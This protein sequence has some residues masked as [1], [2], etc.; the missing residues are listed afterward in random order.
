MQRG[1]VDTSTALGTRELD[2]LQQAGFTILNAPIPNIV[3]VDFALEKP[4][5]DKKEVRQ[6]I[7]YAMPYSNLL[8][9]VFSGRGEVATSYVNPQ[10]PGFLPAFKPYTEGDTAKAKDLLAKAGVGNGF[11]VDLYYDNGVPYNENLALVV[12]DALRQLNI[13]VTLKAEP[14]TQFAD[15]R[16]ARVKGQQVMQGMLLQSAVIWLDDPDPNTDVWV[17]SKGTSNDMGYNNPE[18][19]ALH[20]QNRFSSDTASRNQ[21]YGKIQQMVADDVPL[22]PL[23][24]TGRNAA[25]SPS[26]TQFAFTADP[27]NRFWTL[28]LKK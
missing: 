11:A 26:I 25:L 2:S 19:D 3:R 21:A 1:E 10:S 4:P 22:L 17:S 8:K 7:A 14:T 6:A 20:A 28:Q 15:E 24:V 18:L 12:Q 16:T 9:N 5:L 27:H 23:L 13:T